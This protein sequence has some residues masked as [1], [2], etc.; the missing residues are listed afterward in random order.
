MR[1]VFLGAAALGGV[2]I[3]AGLVGWFLG[4]TDAALIIGAGTGLIS[5]A[6]G[7]KA[8]QAQAENRGPTGP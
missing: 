2:T 1:V 8:W 3:L 6:A 7:A 4:K 5:M